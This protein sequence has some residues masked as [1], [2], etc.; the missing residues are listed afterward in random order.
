[1][2]WNSW[3]YF[4]CNISQDLIKSTVDQIKNLNLDKFGYKYVNIDD[5]WQFETRDS[6]GY[7]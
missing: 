5:C 6:N 2:G 1:M 3:N 7:I 4:H